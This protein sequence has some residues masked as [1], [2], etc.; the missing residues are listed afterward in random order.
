VEGVRELELDFFISRRSWVSIACPTQLA[1]LSIQSSF[2]QG[3]CRPPLRALPGLQHLLVMGA[4]NDEGMPCTPPFCHD[5]AGCSRLTALVMERCGM[6][7]FPPGLS[8]L[9]SLQRLSLGE[10]DL[11]N[12]R[13][14]PELAALP[15]LTHLAFRKCGLDAVP[16]I[17]SRLTCLRELSLQANWDLASGWQHLSALRAL[18]VLDLSFTKLTH[19]PPVL[20][21]LT[22]LRKP[23][24]YFCEQLGDEDAAW[25]PLASHPFLHFIHTPAARR[26][27][28]T[29]MWWSEIDGA[30]MVEEP[31]H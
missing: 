29:G 2:V 6:D 14:W 7:E 27:A 24:L 13:R 12:A 3:P 30:L 9:S 21:S 16:P 26:R 22:N 25:Q 1:H 11:P 10:F 18:S 28:V 5:L 17:I 20:S 4:T 8:T 15:H 31:A 19:L 23:N